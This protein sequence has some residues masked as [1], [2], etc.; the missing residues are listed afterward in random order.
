MAGQIEKVGVT[1]NSF[2]N[3]DTVHAPLGKYHHNV[4]VPGASEWLVISG[5]VGRDREG[6]V[7]PS[8]KEQAELAFRNVLACLEAGGMGKADLVKLTTYLTDARF[9]GD[10]RAARAAVIGDDTL[11]ASTLV[12]VAGLAAP[13]FLIEVEAWAAKASS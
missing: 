13:E 11:P 9:V 2:S 5:Q 8:V 7:P 4:S 3:P 12:I 10:Y 1:M 6:N